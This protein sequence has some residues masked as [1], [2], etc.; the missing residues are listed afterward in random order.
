[1]DGNGIEHDEEHGICWKYVEMDQDDQE[2]DKSNLFSLCCFRSL[3]NL[4]FSLS[5][6]TYIWVKSIFPFFALPI[7]ENI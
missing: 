1:M 6:V 7:R 2:K 3:S 4:S 5:S